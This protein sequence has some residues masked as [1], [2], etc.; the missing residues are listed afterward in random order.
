M[1]HTEESQPVG[2]PLF[3]HLDRRQKA[4][5]QRLR[6][7]PR[8]VRGEAPEADHR[9]ENRT[10]RTETTKGGGDAD[11]AG[12]GEEQEERKEESKED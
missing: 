6:P 4:R 12:S 3:T 10:G 1:H 7:Y 2:G 8:R 11:T 9:D 5:P